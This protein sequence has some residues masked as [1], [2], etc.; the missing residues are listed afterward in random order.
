[1]YK[2]IC[3]P[4]EADWWM[5]DH[6]IECRKIPTGFWVGLC[7]LN[8]NIPNEY[9]FGKAGLLLTIANK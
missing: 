4:K 2:M 9:V 1:M 3:N 8:L 7:H 5:I 6:T